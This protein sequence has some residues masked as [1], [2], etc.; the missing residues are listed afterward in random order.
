MPA[1]NMSKLKIGDQVRLPTDGCT[2]IIGKLVRFDK[3]EERYGHKY[4]LLSKQGSSE[5]IIYCTHGLI[6]IN[7]RKP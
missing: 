4:K 5:E 1:K 3:N 6:K 7:H 2:D